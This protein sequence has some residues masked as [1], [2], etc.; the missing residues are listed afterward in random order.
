MIWSSYVLFIA[1]VLASNTFNIPP[2]DEDLKA[3]PCPCPNTCNI[4]ASKCQVKTKTLQLIDV[5]I[6]GDNLQRADDDYFLPNSGINLIMEACTDMPGC[7]SKWKLASEAFEGFQG[8]QIVHDPKSMD[9]KCD[10]QIIVK[11]IL[12]VS[13]GDPFYQSYA[14][15]VVTTWVPDADC[16]Y[17][18][19]SMDAVSMACSCTETLPCSLC[20]AQMIR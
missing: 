11:S 4:A 17:K 6:S 1:A 10:G 14:F 8:A 18:I 15:N 19:I 2:G 13:Y 20:Q 5:L 3:C 9:A 7:C 12:V 16:D